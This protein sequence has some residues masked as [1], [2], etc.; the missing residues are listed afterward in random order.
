MASPTAAQRVWPRWIGPVGLA[1]M[2]STLTTRPASAVPCPHASPAVTTRRASSPWLALS[3]RMLT[4][5]GPATSALA[6]PGTSASRSASRAARSRGGM[7]AFF[8][9]ARATL[10]A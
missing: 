7:P 9:S 8:A 2:N 4:N 5:P 1:E 3:S 6:T 10:V